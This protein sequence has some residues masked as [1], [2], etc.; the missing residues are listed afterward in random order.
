L[1]IAEGYIGHM[2]NW[3]YARAV[4]EIKYIVHYKHYYYGI[5]YTFREVDKCNLTVVAIGLLKFKV[6]DSKPASASKITP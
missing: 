1:I 4:S 5:F 6:T 2:G 3:R